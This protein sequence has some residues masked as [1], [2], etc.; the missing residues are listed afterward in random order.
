MK[1]AATHKTVRRN[2]FTDNKIVQWVFFSHFTSL[3]VATYTSQAA[4]KPFANKQG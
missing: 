1:N 3:Q 2:P 4:V